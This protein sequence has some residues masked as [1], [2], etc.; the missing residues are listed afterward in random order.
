MKETTITEG[1]DGRNKPFI[2]AD[3]V[4]VYIEIPK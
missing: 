1:W 3:Y 2:I 4:I